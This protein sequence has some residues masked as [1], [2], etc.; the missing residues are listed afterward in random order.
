M[1]SVRVRQ[2][3]GRRHRRPRQQH[4]GLAHARLRVTLDT[5]L[6]PL[7]TAKAAT[8]E[9]RGG[10][11]GSLQIT[12]GRVTWRLFGSPCRPADM[13]ARRSCGLK[14]ANSCVSPSAATV[15]RIKS[16]Y[17][18]RRVQVPT[19]AARLLVFP[20]ISSNVIMRDGNSMTGRRRNWVRSPDDAAPRIRFP[21]NWRILRD[22]ILGSVA[23][24]PGAFL[25]T[26]DEL[27]AKPPEYWEGRLKSSTW[28]VVE[29][30]EQDPR[31]RRG[32]AAERGR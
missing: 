1:T 19:A 3:C 6:S 32:E 30:E 21:R 17:R 14:G 24:S 18:N 20:A 4:N 10:R 12:I 15:T 8:T 5:W 13:A 16:Y 11:S 22:T 9:H 23:T 28:A 7:A 31:H 26:A 2:V 29:R 25:A 27:E